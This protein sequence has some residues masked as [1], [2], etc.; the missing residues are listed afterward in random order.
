[1]EFMWAT[2]HGQNSYV[3][4]S[5][6][7]SSVQS[8]ISSYFKNVKWKLLLLM[9]PFKWC[10]C[11]FSLTLWLVSID[12]TTKHSS[13]YFI[14]FIFFKLTEF[15]KWIKNSPAL[16]S[17]NYLYHWGFLHDME[18]RRTKIPSGEFFFF[19]LFLIDETPQGIK[20]TSGQFVVWDCKGKYESCLK[21]CIFFL[22]FQD[23][24]ISCLILEKWNQKR[25]WLIL[26]IFW[27]LQ[28]LGRQPTHAVLSV[29]SVLYWM[30][31]FHWHCG[32]GELPGD[33]KI[34][35]IKVGFFLVF[36]FL[37]IQMRAMRAQK[38]KTLFDPE[39][40]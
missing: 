18:Q 40:L 25:Y 2:S 29:L 3:C 12:C 1:M 30:V 16:I 19:F 32:F 15:H 24:Q 38:Q 13:F 7:F 11:Q 37:V 27:T 8:I 33:R 34:K 21:R 20:A 26:V 9:T 10:F 28:P 39:N 17:K 35:I 5:G 36:F 23:T 14:L 6:Q 22:G 4:R 31:Q